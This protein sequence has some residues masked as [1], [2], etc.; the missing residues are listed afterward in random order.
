MNAIISRRCLNVQF[1][2][3]NKLDFCREP[4]SFLTAFQIWSQT[5]GISNLQMPVLKFFGWEGSVSLE[6]IT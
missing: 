1:I 4:D 3:S 5:T 2:G 6:I